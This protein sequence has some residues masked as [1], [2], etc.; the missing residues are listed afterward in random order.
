MIVYYSFYCILILFRDEDGSCMFRYVYFSSCVD[1]DFVGVVNINIEFLVGY[2]VNIVGN[3]YF[4][5]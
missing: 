4:R 5:V 3:G 2:I 1:L